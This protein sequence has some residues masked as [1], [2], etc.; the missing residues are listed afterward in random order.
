MIQGRHRRWLNQA[1][2][3]QAPQGPGQHNTNSITNKKNAKHLRRRSPAKP[4]LITMFTLALLPTIAL[5]VS[6][7][8]DKVS[9][10]AA[11]AAT[12]ITYR[13][14]KASRS[15]TRPVSKD[16]SKDFPTKKTKP[17]SL[18]TTPVK[19]RAKPTETVSK[20]KKVVTKKL[21]IKKPV[22]KKKTVKKTAIIAVAGLDFSPCAESRSIESGVGLNARNLYRAVCHAFPKAGPF[23]GYRND[24]DSYH[25]KGRAID[26]MVP[27][28]S[29]GEQVRDWVMSNRKGLKA[30]E[31]IWEQHIWTLTRPLWRIMSDRG[32]ATANHYDH[33]H[34]SLL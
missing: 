2:K 32:G 17:A 18:P 22:E 26:I 30:M 1:P 13:Q 28:H 33:V 7:A 9:L 5:S 16:T 12:Q 15:G 4:L 11:A 8:N 6:D 31:I 3:P 25:G 20:T 34:V 19:K 14:I 10:D 27:S 21:E 23:G 29:V 24:S